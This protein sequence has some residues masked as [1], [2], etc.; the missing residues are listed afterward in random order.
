MSPGEGRRSSLEVGV[1]L[2]VGLAVEVGVGN[3]ACPVAA[4]GVGNAPPHATSTSVTAS[5]MAMQ[6]N[7]G[8]LLIAT[9]VYA[10]PPTVRSLRSQ[11]ERRGS[12]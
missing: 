9:G 5:T 1:G 12:A 2:G 7:V 10:R 8:R 6:A 3:S 11:A 4:V